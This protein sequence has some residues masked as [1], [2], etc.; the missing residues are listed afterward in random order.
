MLRERREA[1]PRRTRS[2][3]QRRVYWNASLPRTAGGEALMTDQLPLDCA[4]DDGGP[5][6]D[7]GGPAPEI[8]VITGMSGAGRSEAIHTFE[9]LG[10]FCIDNLPPSFIPQLVELAELPGSRI[11]RLA[12]VCDVRAH[13][14]F[15]ELAGELEVA[16][17]ARHRLP[18]ALPRGRR[19]DAA[20]GAS[21]R[22]AA[23]IRCARRARRW[24][25]ASGR[26][27]GAR[28]RSA[29]APT[30]SSTPRSSS[31]ASCATRSASALQRVR[32]RARS[33]SRS[34]PSASSTACRPTPTS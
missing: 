22:R 1:P 28:A 29:R 15:D 34:R 33:R 20:R 7:D 31:R 27:R 17:R 9:D 13:G 5:V 2:T 10:F 24:S 8:V 16:R 26:A 18:R 11:R 23:A 32:S 19:R 21:R 6:R 25:T 12:V 30:S 3:S 4:P 14:F